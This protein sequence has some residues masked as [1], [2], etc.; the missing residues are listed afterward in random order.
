MLTLEEGM[1]N[2]WLPGLHSVKGTTKEGFAEW[3]LKREYFFTSI[4]S[5]KEFTIRTITPEKVLASLAHSCSKMSCAAFETFLGMTESVNVLPKSCG[6]ISVKAYYGAFFAAHAILRMCGTICFQID[7]VQKSALEKEANLLTSKSTHVF[8][9][10]FYM[11]T[12]DE[13]NCEITLKKTNAS[14]FG[15][16]GVMWEAFDSELRRFS[17]ELLARSSLFNDAAL[18]LSDI[19]SS[20]SQAGA[21]GTWLSSVRNSVNYRF[22]F[23]AW[24]PYKNLVADKKSLFEIIRNWQ[25]HPQKLKLYHPKDTLA[26][27]VSTSVAIASLCNLIVDDMN[28]A[29][30]H[31]SF[32]SYG[33]IALLRFARKN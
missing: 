14:T 33:P 5:S 26:Q 12:F 29:V 17:N 4:K 31:R 20:L 11:G 10:G 6:W 32:Q 27:Q 19:S 2:F 16:H 25:E 18:F 21:K 30:G 1:R 22:D 28:K 8:E 7:G 9:T 15:S 24:F 23:G 3:M 13:K